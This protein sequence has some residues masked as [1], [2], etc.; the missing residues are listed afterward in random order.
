MKDYNQIF[1]EIIKVDCTNK[2]EKNLVLKIMKDINNGEN[3]NIKEILDS[4]KRNVLTESNEFISDELGRFKLIKFL[5]KISE[6]L[7]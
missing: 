3:I 5:D 6:K 7:I 2:M 1:Q 4:E